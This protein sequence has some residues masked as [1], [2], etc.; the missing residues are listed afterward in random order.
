[1]NIAFL[2]D[3]WTT[4]AGEMAVALQKDGSVMAGFSYG[5][6]DLESLSVNDLDAL[7]A[8]WN[9][10]LARLG[11]DW[12]V[13]VSAIREPADGYI[14]ESDNAFQSPVA[15]LID[16]ERRAQYG[17]ESH[18]FTSRY[19]YIIT[20]RLPTDAEAA[21][22][23]G[24][25]K[26]KAGRGQEGSDQDRFKELMARFRQPM[27][28][29]LG[30]FRRNYRVRALDADGLL[31]H[32]HECLTGQKHRVNAP[33]VPAYLD[34]LVG[35][36]DFVGGLEPSIDGEEIRVV[37]AVGYPNETYPEMLEHLHS[38][39]F[40]LRYTLR[41]LPLDQADAVHDMSKIRGKWFG[42][43]T[44]LKAQLGEKFSG[45][46]PSELAADDHAT[47]LALDAKQGVNEAREGAVKFGFFTLTVVLRDQ[48]EKILMERVKT[49]KN[50]FDNAGYVAY[51]E[52]VNTV[53]ALLGSLPGHMH[54]NIRRPILHSLNFADFAPKTEIWAGSARCPSPLMKMSDGRK[55]PPLLYAATT[56]NT[57][58]RFNLHV[59]DLGH[60]FIAGMPGSGK[61]TLLALLAA[62]WQRYQGAR[63]I[64]FDKGMSLY[65]MTEA[66]EGQHYDLNGPLSDLSFAPLGHIDDPAELAFAAEWVEGLATL[67]GLNVTSVERTAIRDGLN[68]LARESGRSM[69][70][71]V[72]SIQHAGLKEAL[73]FYTLT[74][75]T[76]AL[77]DAEK[78]GLQ[79]DDA[80]MMTFEMSH[81][82][83]GSPAMKRTT[84]PVLLYLF[85]R[86][87][88]MLDGRPTLILLDEAWTFLD[89]EL[90]LAKLRQWLKELR[91]KNAAVVFATQSLADLKGNPLLPVLQESCPSKIFLPNAQA[92]GQQLRP[93][94]EDMGLNER[95]IQMLKE[96]TPKQD[97]YL[98]TTEGQRR[99]Q[100]GMG[101]VTL[102]FCG[103]SDPRDVKRVADLK[104]QNGNRW[105]LYW[106]REQLPAQRQDWVALLQTMF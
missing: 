2:V 36:H 60:T 72:Q 53:E 91:K 89:D 85:H 69:T 73:R 23:Q 27:D 31:T 9:N 40:P 46:A 90:F 71:L 54:E 6:P 74:G 82:M 102:A 17:G 7:S 75:Q 33:H 26:K 52:T 3:S 5:G 84:V 50:F 58:F 29:I 15:S 65:A 68:S 106:L 21:I 78:D 42:S 98:F 93:L 25:V 66:T 11:T 39:P 97:Y 55:A 34:A 13:H 12:G 79:V 101:P 8:A 99:I 80:T 43:R 44:S 32:V 16:L 35:H 61:S 76:G 47:N 86:I 104:A 30:I 19:Y 100:F 51:L 56:G 105:P 37:T 1:M 96:S 62:Q 24:L 10:G 92:D 103:V 70:N 64:A 18:H 22:G 49:V 67:Q 48:D 41:F 38:L 77:L 4:D 83:N 95:Q 81:L 63:V 57:P 87:E 88:Q 59:G 94:Y 28:V 45:E 14:P 20:W